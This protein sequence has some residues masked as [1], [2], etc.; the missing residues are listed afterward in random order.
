MNN[1]ELKSAKILVVDD[2][3]ANIELLKML[4]KRWGFL[5]VVATSDSTEAVGLVRAVRPDLILLDLHMPKMDGF[6]V[7]K[8]IRE[9]TAIDDYL[10]VLVLT[11]DITNVTKQ[12]ALSSGARD[13]LVKPFDATE[14]LLRVTNLLETRHLHTRLENYSTDLAREVELRTQQITQKSNELEATRLEIL[15]RLASAAEFR[16]DDTGQHTIRVGVL[17]AEIARVL[18]KDMKFVK[19]M[20]EAAPLHDLGKIGI[21]D[22]ILLKPGKLTPEEWEIMKSHT[23]IGAK[24]LAGSKDPL[25]RL[26]EEIALTHHEKWNGTGYMRM[27]GTEIPLSGRIVA[28]ADVFDA[29]TNHRPYKK[30]W[31]REEAV[32]EI[33]KQRGEHF[34][35]Q[36]VD[37]F[38]IVLERMISE[39]RELHPGDAARLNPS[40]SA[41]PTA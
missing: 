41:T 5:N 27:K 14:V 3:W 34:D 7:L 12:R 36:V 25:L 4:L 31:T 37:A 11:A 23:A 30:A 16:D 20:R 24:I 22:E 40:I 9:V 17:S 26:S 29:L 8:G 2:E 18:G 21:P 32:A 38:Q 10:P 39:S 33:L 6:E 15:K 1:E 13:F 35:P 19:D 28:I